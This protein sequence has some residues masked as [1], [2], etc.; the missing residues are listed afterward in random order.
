MFFGDGLVA[1]HGNTVSYE[2]T[3]VFTPDAGR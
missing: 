1:T 2:S 3:T